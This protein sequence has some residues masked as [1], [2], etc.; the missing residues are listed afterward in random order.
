M[1]K[2][3]LLILKAVW[4]R[5]SLKLPCYRVLVY[6]HDLHQSPRGALHY[7]ASAIRCL[8]SGCVQRFQLWQAAC[9][10]IPPN[11]ITSRLDAG[12]GQTE[13]VKN[14]YLFWSRWSLPSSWLV[15]FIL[16]IWSPL[17]GVPGS[18]AGG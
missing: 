16:L 13:M 12:S 4:S 10:K 7:N 14:I 5:C 17:V 1:S 15:A 2:N 8:P 18:S 6:I 11:L 9:T 3:S